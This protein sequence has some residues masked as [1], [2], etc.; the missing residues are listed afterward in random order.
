MNKRAAFFFLTLLSLALTVAHPLRAAPAVP[1]ERDGRVLD[2]LLVHLLSDPRFVFSGVS[3]SQSTILLH[4]S[5]P[6]SVGDLQPETMRINIV[7]DYTLPDDALLDLRRRNPPRKASPG[8]TNAPVAAYFTN[9]TFSPGIIVTNLSSD[10]RTDRRSIV[11]MQFAYP[12]ARGWVEANLPGYSNDGSSAVVN[13]Y[14]GPS[15]HGASLIAFLKKS[16]DKWTV[17]WVHFNFYV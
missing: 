14:I 9:L 6:E 7:G 1:D 2:A 5:T 3:T 12:K 17:K 10:L 11:E 15:A 8:D 4:A 16:G 13:A